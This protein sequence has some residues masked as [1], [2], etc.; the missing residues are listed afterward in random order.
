MIQNLPEITA[1]EQESDV[2]KARDAYDAL[3][4]DLKAQV[5]NLNLLEAA[6]LKITSLKDDQAAVWTK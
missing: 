6:E 1:L 4:E 3:T 5:Y 2:V